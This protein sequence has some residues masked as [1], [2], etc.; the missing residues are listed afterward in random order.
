MGIPEIYKI[1]RTK[2]IRIIL[3]KYRSQTTVENDDL[4]VFKRVSTQESLQTFAALLLADTGLP[5]TMHF[6][7]SD[8]EFRKTYKYQEHVPYKQ[9]DIFKVYSFERK[10]L[11]HITFEDIDQQNGVYWWTNYQSY[12]DSS[13]YDRS[14]S[15]QFHKFTKAD[16]NMH[17]FT[18]VSVPNQ[19]PDSLI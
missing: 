4:G 11:F 17:K 9:G 7:V 3:S 8:E 6:H 19:E 10:H 14:A 15:V 2:V 13:T 5:N 1:K 18:L 12:N 16:T